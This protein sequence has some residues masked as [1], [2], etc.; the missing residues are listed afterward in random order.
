MWSLIRARVEWVV[1]FV[2]PRLNLVHTIRKSLLHVLYIRINGI[3]VKKI[4]SY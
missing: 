4:S 3:D 1:V 2:M